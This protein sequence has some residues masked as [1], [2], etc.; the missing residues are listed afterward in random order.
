MGYIKKIIEL[1]SGDNSITTEDVS[2]INGEFDMD[3]ICGTLD[4]NLPYFI[5][6]PDSTVPQGISTDPET[7]IV[8]ITLPFIGTF[9][10][11]ITREAINTNN[12]KK[13]DTVRLYYQEFTEDPGEITNPS[14]GVFMA[15]GHQL[16]KIF[17]GFIDEIK[18]SKAKTDIN[19]NIKALG[20]LGLANYRNLSYQHKT[21]TAYE[22]FLTLLQI[23]GLQR[24]DFNVYPVSQDSIPVDMVRFIDVDAMN[25]VWN[26]EGGETL[27]DA[28]DSIKEKYSIIIHQSGDGYVNVMTPIFLLGAVGNDTLDIYGWEFNINDGT[29]YNV[30]YGDFTN[31]YNAVVVLGAPPV[32]GV[33]VDPITVSNNDGQVN[34]I[35]H[36]NRN[37]VSDEECQRTARNKLLELERNFFMSFT[38]KFSPYFMIGQPFKIIDNDRFTGRETFLIK[39]YSFVIDKQDVSCTITGMNQGGTLVPEEIALSD[40]GVLDVDILQIRDKELDKTTWRDVGGS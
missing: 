4:F 35:I 3:N 23:S 7:T 26:I 19:Y 21:G 5:P 36:E 11:P 27:K 20:T 28:I 13:F 14:G 6:L 17:D 22:L 29:L 16:P 8:P 34:Y 25:W 24:G 2:N 18:L 30:D 9:D 10:I 39:K 40:I 32:Y 15:G 1:G 38:T 12:L 31:Y 33:A 37:L